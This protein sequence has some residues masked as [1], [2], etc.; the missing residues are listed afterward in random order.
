MDNL[1][2]VIISLVVMLIGFIVA[3]VMLS[4]NNQKLLEKNFN[5]KLRLN[6]LYGMKY[7]FNA[8]DRV[9]PKK[10]DLAKSHSICHESWKKMQEHGIVVIRSE[11]DEE[12]GC[13]TV[14]VY[15]KE[16]NTFFWFEAECLEK[17][18]EDDNGT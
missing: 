18:E 17:I 10:Y 5:L 9:R 2:L 12:W 8:G 3:N 11:Y 4:I 16:T 15:L 7:T 14:L 6:S 13:E 1:Y